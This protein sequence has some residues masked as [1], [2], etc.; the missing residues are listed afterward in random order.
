VAIKQLC[1]AAGVVKLDAGEQGAVLAFHERHFAEPAGLVAFIARAGEG[2]RLRP[3]HALVVRRDWRDPA[4]RLKALEA[5][6]GELAAI[7]G[8]AAA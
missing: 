1:R 8:R 5:L 3:D 7:A 4:A 6:L 2:V